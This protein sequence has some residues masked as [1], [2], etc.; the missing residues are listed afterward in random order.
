MNI[1]L[2]ILQ[3]AGRWQ[4]F[5]DSK[6]TNN[7]P[8]YIGIGAALGIIIII[9]LVARLASSRKGGGSEKAYRPGIFRKQGKKLGLPDNHIKILETLIKRYNINYPYNLLKNTSQLDQALSKAMREVEAS[10]ATAEVKASQKQALFRIKQIIE[11]KSQKKQTLPTTKQMKVNQALVLA[12]SSG[13]RYRSRVVS[14]LPEALSVEAPLTPDGKLAVTKRWQTLKVYFWKESGSAF[15]FDTK[16][17][18]FK[19]AGS[20]QTLLLQHANHVTQ[21]QQRRYRRKE[22]DRPAYYYR[23]NIVESGR[24]RKKTK[25]AVVDSQVRSLGTILEI[26]AGG[27]SIKTT[28]PLQKGDLIKVQFEPVKRRPVVAFGKVRQISRRKPAGYVMHVM[29]T[30]VSRQNLNV[31]N[32]YIYEFAEA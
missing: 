22:V 15:S 25:E 29:F 7:T 23:V 28:A 18:G 6:P 26:S 21:S 17:V 31:I 10:A 30:K 20:L 12:P 19:P 14:V 5:G 13:G 2:I 9:V 24:G 16:V 27:C 8:A 4:G 3:A 11:L 1:P 32:E